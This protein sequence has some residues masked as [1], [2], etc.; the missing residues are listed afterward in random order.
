MTDNLFRTLHILEA[1][2]TL[3]HLH[4]RVAQGNGRILIV[5]SEGALNCV[6]LSKDELDSLER[7]LEILADAEHFKIACQ[8][9]SRLSVV[10]PMSGNA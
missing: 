7:A 2:Q 3:P 6:L 1:Q 5:D 4:Q 9:L 10:D 8:T